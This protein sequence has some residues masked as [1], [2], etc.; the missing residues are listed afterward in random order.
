MET[1]KEILIIVPISAIGAG[2][3][4]LGYLMVDTHFLTAAL[5]GW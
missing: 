2:I 1:I 4:L 3:V 5:G